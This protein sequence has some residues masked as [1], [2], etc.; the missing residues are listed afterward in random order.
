MS[1]KDILERLGIP[2]KPHLEQFARVHRW[3]KRLDKIRFSNSQESSQPEHYDFIYAFFTNCYHLRDFLKHS[4]A[5]QTKL[6]D[7]FF[8]KNKEMQICRDICN[9]SKHCVLDSP[10]IGLEILNTN[11]KSAKGWAGVC[12]IREYDPFQEV[13]KNDNPV[14]N[15][16]YVVLA[17][18]KKY[19]VF[20]LADKCYQ[21]WTNFFKENKLL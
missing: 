19:N 10:S 21:L 8:T 6:V 20:E 3:K 7:E 14:K 18:G 9:E 4:K 17:D 2:V 1:R 15:I 16:K 12:L 11:K 5:I 13:L